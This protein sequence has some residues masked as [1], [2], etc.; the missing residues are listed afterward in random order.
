MSSGGSAASASPRSELTS[1]TVPN[2]AIRQSSL[3]TRLP[4]PRLVS[5]VSPARIDPGQAHRLVPRTR[6][7]GQAQAPSGNVLRSVWSRSNFSTQRDATL[8]RG[9]GGRSVFGSRC[10]GG[11]PSFGSLRGSVPRL[12]QR[13]RGVGRRP[14]SRS[15]LREEARGLDILDLSGVIQRRGPALAS[16]LCSRRGQLERLVGG[17][18]T[19]VSRYASATVH[20]D[21]ER[22]SE[23][24]FSVRSARDRA[25]ERRL[26]PR[27]CSVTS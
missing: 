27:G 19:E 25:L 20:G 26:K 2:A 5:P 15:E 23:R 16:L 11:T 1:S 22:V 10:P 6:H 12:R 8:T 24:V 9:L 18:K 7:G 14:S 21:G 3:G 4:S 13:L 17:K